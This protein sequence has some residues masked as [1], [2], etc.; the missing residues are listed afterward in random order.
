MLEA[1]IT[2]PVIVF[3]LMAIVQW[4]IVW[5]ARGIAQA[6]A[7]EGLRTAVAYGSSEAAGQQD[8][9]NYIAQVAPH[10]LTGAQVDVSRTADTITVRIHAAVPSLI[11][12][13]SF[14][15]TATAAGPAEVWSP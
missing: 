14:S 1:A 10:A 3:L 6:A 8:I 7:Q 2:L 15:V 11:P 13:G 5:H 12:F 9:A 4:A